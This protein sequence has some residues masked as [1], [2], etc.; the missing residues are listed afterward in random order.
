MVPPALLGDWVRSNKA[1]TKEH[2]IQLVM[3][4]VGG[5]DFSF[6]FQLSL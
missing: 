2:V 4:P 5:G 6:P 1:F 3:A